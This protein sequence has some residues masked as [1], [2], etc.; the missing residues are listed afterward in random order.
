MG[1]EITNQ[2]RNQIQD[3]AVKTNLTRVQIGRWI[4]YRQKCRKEKSI[5]AE[6]R[7]MLEIFFYEISKMPTEAEIC[8][9]AQTTGLTKLKIV[10]WFRVK[11]H[12]EKKTMSRL[13][14]I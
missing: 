1:R 11:R 10:S 14:T 9:L 3:L 12:R 4:R 13:K 5:L 6:R 8:K 2:L 7:E